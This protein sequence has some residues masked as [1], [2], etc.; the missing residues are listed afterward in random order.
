MR[1]TIT[2]LQ[3]DRIN[4]KQMPYAIFET[5]NELEINRKAQLLHTK[6]FH[7]GLIK[8]NCGFDVLNFVMFIQCARPQISYAI[9]IF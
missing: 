7:F 2:F 6:K 3:S 5:K 9:F 1:S 8:F 4:V